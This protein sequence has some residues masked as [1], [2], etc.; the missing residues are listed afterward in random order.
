MPISRAVLGFRAFWEKLLTVGAGG[1]GPKGLAGMK[2]L[3][4]PVKNNP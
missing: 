4:P 1:V 2:A 3:L